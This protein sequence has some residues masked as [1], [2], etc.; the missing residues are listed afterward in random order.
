[1]VDNKCQ[2]CG[3]EFKSRVVRKYC[4]VEH[5]RMCQRTMPFYKNIMRQCGIQSR[6]LL[7]NKRLSL[8]GKKFGRL[9]VL[10]ATKDGKITKWKCICDCG[11]ITY[12]RT[13]LLVSGK[14]RS[15][16]C[17]R[18]ELS[19]KG[20]APGESA[21]KKLYRAYKSSCLKLNRVFNLSLNEFSRL[22]KMD[23]Y[24]CGRKPFSIL[25]GYGNGDYCYNGIDRI[26]S[27]IGYIKGNI[28]TAC[29]DCNI[30]KQSMGKDEFLNLIALIYKNL[31]LEER[32]GCN[33][34]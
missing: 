4:C 22:T 3:K 33:Q 31:K 6:N 18:S 24:Y 12:I 28:V 5:Y 13:S 27:K 8:E 19:R 32:N 7:P 34:D 2:F 20:N 9:K 21:M 30:A 29:K 15:C 26:D 1:M 25:R 14:T 17:L 16:G 23:C 11:T 10:E